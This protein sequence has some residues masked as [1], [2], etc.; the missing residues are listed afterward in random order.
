MKAALNIF[1]GDRTRTGSW[2]LGWLLGLGFFLSN[3]PMNAQS[4]PP[5]PAQPAATET[6]TF[7]GGCFWCMEAV[8]ERLDGVKSVV[9]GYAGG[10]TVNPTYE[11]VC[12]GETGHAETIQIEFDPKK[13][14]Y[15]D[16]LDIF[17][18]A[19]D[20]TTLNRQGA[21]TGTQYRSVI[22]YQNAAQKE[23]AEKSKKAA[24]ADFDA[25]IVTE[26][27]P[28]THFYQAEAYHQDYFRNHPNAPYCYFVIQ[29]KLR[30]LHKK[31]TK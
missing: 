17:W 5:K 21:D 19:H 24:A 13:I 16:L 30:K 1:R 23:E 18:H 29:P 11:D 9:S 28:L 20:P 12:S 25:P 2:L 3:Q 27:V 31:L 26:I 6:A 14:S 10:K 22:F 4:D 15:H 7:A 8:F